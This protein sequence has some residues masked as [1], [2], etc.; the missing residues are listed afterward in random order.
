MDTDEN[1]TPS[2]V[3]GENKTVS[4]WIVAVT[5]FGGFLLAILM[6][7][8][9][10]GFDSELVRFVHLFPLGLVIVFPC[11]DL[12]GFLGYL[13]YPV[14]FICAFIYR[15]K[16]TFIKLLI[17]YIILLCLNITGCALIWHFEI[18]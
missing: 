2:K 10:N 5:Y 14:I 6:A 16:S 3:E 17:V 12:F 11:C 7:W 4:K 13:I 1:Q 15:S 18:F 9:C 8:A